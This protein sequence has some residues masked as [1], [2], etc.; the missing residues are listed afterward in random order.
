MAFSSRGDVARE[1]DIQGAGVLPADTRGPFAPASLAAEG[2]VHLSFPHQLEGTL[3][4]HFAGHED[5]FLIE[6]DP[7]RFGSN[8]RLD[9]SRGGAPFPH[10]YRAL[11][12]EELL[13]AWALTR[14][15]RWSVPR[16]AATDAAYDSPSGRADLV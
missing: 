16:F 3:G 6:V 7:S 1:A 14:G 12:A 2:F 5:V 15:A 11:A 13:R 9:V 10:L 8:L 4:T